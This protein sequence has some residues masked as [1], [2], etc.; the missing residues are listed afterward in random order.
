MRI[1][2]TRTDRLGDVVL[3]TPVIRL[4]RRTYPD[5]HIAF[6]VRPQNRDAVMNN[7]DLDEVITYDKYGRHDGLGGTLKFSM[8]LRKKK[9]DTAIALHPT[10]RVHM[11][12]FLAGISRRIGYN[13]KMGWLLT[14]RVH[15]E[16]QLGEVHEAAYNLNL[17]EKAGFD[18][19]DV[20]IRPYIRTTEEDKKL[21]DSVKKS[22]GLGDKIIAI[23]AGAS[24]ESKRW[25]LGM[26]SRVADELSEKYHCDIVLVGGDE[27]SEYSAAVMAD[28][29]TRATDLT[30]T[31]LLGELAELLSRTK[32]F[33]SN[34][35]GP[36]HVAVAVGAPVIAIFGRN[37]PGLSPKRWGPLGGKDIVLHKS[38]GCDPC[39]AHNCDK[40][41]QCLK[42]ITVEDVIIAADKILNG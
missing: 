23:H 40:Q 7:P 37:D 36:V 1:L 20:D 17:L 16:K 10:N 34:D 21:I 5:A 25:S 18:I 29:K 3:S 15:Y 8:F 24:C 9:F 30:G 6:M 38:P 41:F 27:T 4:V 42:A 31:L 39:L 2:I 35:S 19:K 32:L 28:M 22:S 12:L 11:I 26:F 13:K 33:I 14:Q